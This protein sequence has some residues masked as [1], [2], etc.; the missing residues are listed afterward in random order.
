[1]IVYNVVYSTLLSNFTL[2]CQVILTGGKEGGGCFSVFESHQLVTWMYGYSLFYSTLYSTVYITVYSALC[3]ALCSFVFSTLQVCGMFI[4]SQGCNQ[5]VSESQMS[6]CISKMVVQEYAHIQQQYYWVIPIRKGHKPKPVFFFYS[7]TFFWQY[8]H[9]FKSEQEDI[10]I[11]SCQ[12][13]RTKVNAYIESRF[14]KRNC[15]LNV[16]CELGTSLILRVRDICDVFSTNEKSTITN[17]FTI[18]KAK[19]E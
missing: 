3:S 17:D 9:I 4:N 1:M 11:C 14:F 10:C 18:C 6:I 12:H 16:S 13:I 7:K 8:Y 19:I 5:Q 2:Q 15:I